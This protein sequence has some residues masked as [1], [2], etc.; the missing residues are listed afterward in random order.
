MCVAGKD[1]KNS[2]NS[3]VEGVK[4]EFPRNEEM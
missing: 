2:R 4:P 3:L 1:R